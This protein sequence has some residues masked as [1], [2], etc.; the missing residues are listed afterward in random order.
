MFVL[1]RKSMNIVVAVPVDEELASFIGKKG[2]SESITFYNR[3][4]GNDVVVALYPSQEDAKIYAL[5]E[6][7][8]VAN[9]VAMSTKNI[10]KRFGEALVASSLLNKKV[11]FTNDN[12]VGALLKSAGINEYE[13]ASREE[14]LDRLRAGAAPAGSEPVRID[15][16]KAFPVKGIGTVVLGVV[17]RGTIRQ[18]DKLFHTSGKEVLVRS[19]QSQDEDVAFAE[20]G[21]RIGISLKDISD[22]EI[23][24]GDI[25]ATH[26]VGRKE[27]VVVD[28]KVSGVVKEK[29]VEG[30]G[31][32]LVV[33]FSYAEC[34]VKSA[35]GSEMELEL[36]NPL[37]VEAEDEALLIR[38]EIPRIFASG[39]I[40][41][42][43]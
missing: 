34:V 2:S 9:K 18:H 31:Y 30:A 33:N 17:T 41:K 24:K 39:K 12:E 4:L 38:K 13:V 3:K 22:E 26:A 8:L 35:S 32:G 15:I 36:K 43:E 37:P 10:D 16:D 40:R 19:L 28:Y 11:I 7:L 23:K 21:T 20:R 25:L 29:P 6:C 42:A 5:A 14:L 27:C 1:Q